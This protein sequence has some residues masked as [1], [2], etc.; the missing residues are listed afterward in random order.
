MVINYQHSL[1]KFQ[2]KKKKKV[3]QAKWIR[4]KKFN[5]LTYCDKNERIL[6][7]K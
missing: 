4:N 2:K 3:T 6:G 5:Y 7:K 1:K